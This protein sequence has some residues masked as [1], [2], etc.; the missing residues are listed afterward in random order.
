MGL[1]KALS[2]L[3]PFGPIF[4]KE[5][6]VT[7]RR[8]RTYFLRFFYLLALLL[9]LLAV[10]TSTSYRNADAMSVAER[11]QQDAE[12]G[13]MFFI[14]F[15]I[16]SIYAL[17]II[18]PILTATSI[19][20]ERL[21]KTL[22]VLLMT[23]ITN[24]QIISGKLFSRLLASLTLIGLSLPVL[25]VVRLLGGVEL[26]QMLA[27]LAL[28]IVAS[29]TAA[30]IGLFY[31]TFMNRAYAVILLSYATM[32]FIYMFVPFIV[33]LT[34]LSHLSSQRPTN[35][36]FSFLLVISPFLNIFA[37][38]VPRGMGM[39]VGTQIIPCVILHLCFTAVLVFWTAAVLRRQARRQ[40]ESEAT[41]APQD[42]IPFAAT[43][44]LSLPPTVDQASQGPP[45]LPYAAVNLAKSKVVEQRSV[46][47]NPVLWREVRRPLMARKWQ[48]KLGTILSI[49]LLL[50]SYLAL[51]SIGGGSRNALAQSEL[52]IGY[53]FVFCA[54][55]TLLICVLS[56]TMIAGEK[57]SDTWILL[58]ATPISARAI[59][60]GKIAGTLRRLLWPSA[61]IAGH[62]LIF[63][64]FGG[65]PISV[66]LMICWII[67]TFNAVWIATG[68]YFSLRMR[69][70][71]FAVISN[72][73]LPL[74]IFGVVPVVLLIL[75]NV[76]DRHRSNL[77]AYVGYY[78]PYYYLGEGISGMASSFRK[79]LGQ[80]RLL[81]LPTSSQTVTAD[82]FLLI[83][84]FVGI[85][86][87]LLSVAIVAYTTARFDRLVGR[88]PQEGSFPPESA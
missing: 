69:T 60:L 14:A 6:R 31:S 43:A 44:D 21:G 55:Y 35:F 24:W 59:I 13:N 45:P 58:L 26:G 68:L 10:Y 72:L 39:G 2:A 49:V 40:G 80:D 63:T 29:L 56:A 57:E 83:V 67:F 75:D 50:V 7:A 38:V 81:D 70:V 27:V 23:P 28:C 86:Y 12:L 79:N 9:V 34:F 87:L 78:L 66:F 16:F 36:F 37:M 25:A 82:G 17:P 11:A 53:S 41:V 85:G 5:L 47:D 74:I 84:L 42:Y 54:L 64:V 3:S 15:S 88:A 22:P 19:S 48:A 32:L 61:F 1:P 65:I 33:M 52:Q 71:T 4:G 30:A 8:K 76:L 20:S 73:L 62:F 46:S 51:A 18:S 77:P